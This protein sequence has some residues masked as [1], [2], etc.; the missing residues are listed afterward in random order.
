MVRIS[1][2]ELIDILER[3]A[4]EKYTEIAKKLKVS[5]TAVRKKIRLLEEQGIIS[6]YVPE[7]NPS[8]IGYNVKALIGIDTAPESYVYLLEK[9]KEVPE[10]R[11][12]YTA[13]GDHMIMIEC[14]FKNSEQ[15]S[16]FVTTLQKHK[17]VTKVC[18][19]II[20]ERVK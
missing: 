15:M 11:K 4:R 6:G 1:N 19:A 17:G 8:R 12:V 3:N 2:N 13:S 14:W 20:H 7:I 18:P 9:I 5:E 10:A 16:R